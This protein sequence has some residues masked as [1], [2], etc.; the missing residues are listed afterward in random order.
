MVNLL[1]TQKPQAKLRSVSVLLLAAVPGTWW[2]VG[3]VL[4]ADC[5]FTAVPLPREESEGGVVDSSAQSQHQVEWVIFESR[6]SY[7]A[8]PHRVKDLQRARLVHSS[9]IRNNT[10]KVKV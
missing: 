2:K 10:D 9:I 1:Q 6:Y 8:S 5:L 7:T 4:V 3:V